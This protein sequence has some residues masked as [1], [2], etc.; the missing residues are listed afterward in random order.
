M[1]L[2]LPYKEQKKIRIWQQNLNKSPTIQQHF[3]YNLKPSNY[4][5]TAIQEPATNSIN[6]VISNSKWNM[7]YLTTH[8]KENTK[9]TW[10]VLFVNKKISK[11]GWHIILLD[12]PDIT[13]IKLINQEGNIQIYNIYHDSNHQDMLTFLTHHL[14]T[15]QNDNNSTNTVGI[16]LLGN[17]NQHHP[18]GMTLAT[19]TY[20]NQPT[21]QQLN[22][23]LTS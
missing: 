1:V 17:F 13:V 23:S 16:I 11:D 20:S 18:S 22:C 9:K 21:Y 8:N 6:L 15:Q 10:S 14:S 2:L 7:I 3:L 4:N 5:I 12:N 19:I